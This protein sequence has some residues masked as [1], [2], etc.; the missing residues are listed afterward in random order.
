MSFMVPFWVYTELGP[1][2]I[3]VSMHAITT[4]VPRMLFIA[5]NDSGSSF[6]QQLLPSGWLLANV[7]NITI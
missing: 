2:P 5:I 3:V 1:A 7:L 6:T 4:L